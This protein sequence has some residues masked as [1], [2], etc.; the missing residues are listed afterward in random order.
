MTPRGKR[1]K[2]KSEFPTLPTG[3]GNPAK[4]KAPDSHIPTA[5]AAGLYQR[6]GE[7]KMEPELNS[8]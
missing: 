6:T 5:P 8:S 4:A 2:L 1:G 3:L 7:E